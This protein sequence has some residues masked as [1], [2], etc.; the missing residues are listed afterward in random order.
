MKTR[1]FI[2]GIMLLLIFA[3]ISVAGLCNSVKPLLYGMIPGATGLNQG[4]CSV[5]SPYTSPDEYNIY[6]N[7]ADTIRFDFESVP[8]FSL[9]L[10]PWQS[11]D[12]DHHITYGIQNHTFPNDTVAK[13]F[14]C[15]NPAAV[16]PPMTDSAIRP[17]GGNKFGA[18][19]SAIPPSNN[20]W[21]ISPKVHLDKN[22][23]FSFWVKSYTALYGLDE[24][25]VLVSVTDSAPGSFTAIS[26]SQ[27]L[28]A[29]VI[30]TKNTYNLSTY[31][32]QNVY[33]AIQCVSNDHFILMIDDIEIITNTA[34]TLIA[35]FT[36][37]KT[38]VAVGEPVN[39]QDRSIGF[40]ATWQWSFPGGTPSTSQVRNPSGIVYSAPGSYDVTLTVGAG[41]L[42]STKT[43][44]GFITVAGYP[45]SASLDFES[46]AD[47]TL[48]FTPWTTVDV[49]GGATY[50]IN[51][52][53]FPH[54]G[55]SMAYICFN[56]FTTSPQEPYLR[57]HSGNKLGCCFSS[58]PNNNP[59]N[60]WLISPRLTLGTSSSL[61]L[62][63]QTYNI[64]YGLE[65]YNIAVSTTDNNPA[66]FVNLT[67]VPELA[68][69][70]WTHQ[71]YDLQ[72]YNN[73][74]V[75]IGIQC[76][77]DNQ[78]IFMVDDIRISSVAGIDNKEGGFT[79]N[80]YPNPAHEKIFISTGAFRGKELK[81]ELNSMLGE[82]VRNLE[83]KADEDTAQL[84]V[85]NLATGVYFLSMTMD[86]HQEV[87]K[88]LIN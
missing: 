53:S 62:W 81:I 40:P 16:T 61:D 64:A 83:I 8:D 9:T 45:S 59:N 84:D 20:D 12:L 70:D 68:P 7:S 3:S 71:T 54:S 57:P 24:Y 74:T 13:A 26:G 86:G 6:G 47:F 65:K 34:D 85:R 43:V 31:N 55:D 72:A 79:L 1:P 10:S 82:K 42:S 22:G 41:V 14:M 18:C 63:V 15:F 32:N 23:L 37:D 77:S 48:D 36:A 2:P 39:F 21:L 49:R 75:Y 52:I 46:L 17:H 73:R 28:L 66:S 87:V 30:W 11:V 25:R 80:V 5:I 33:L 35:E 38:K 29:P 58:M 60:K 27:N 56:P 4:S 69:A 88:I 19:F 67:S 78:F 51:G 50:G 44:N 76:V